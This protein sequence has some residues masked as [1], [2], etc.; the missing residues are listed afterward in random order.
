MPA[1]LLGSVLLLSGATFVGVSR[2][3]DNKHHP[4]DV[5][6]GAIEGVLV[7]CLTVFAFR[8][9]FS[10]NHP[11]VEEEHPTSKSLSD[12]SLSS[13]TADSSA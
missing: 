3:F 5:L 9:T 8:H 4:D 13:A 6:V 10:H 2:V 7:A 11:I 12:I 1:F